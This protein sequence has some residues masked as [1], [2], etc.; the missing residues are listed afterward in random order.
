ME[1]MNRW[2]WSCR[3]AGVS[4]QGTPA[5]D[6]LEDPFFMGAAEGSWGVGLEAVKREDGLVMRDP[7]QIKS[8]W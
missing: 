5:P 7:E 2:T 4:K 1:N 6:G 8:K 3:V